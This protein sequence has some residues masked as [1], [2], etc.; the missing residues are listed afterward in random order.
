MRTLVAVAAGVVT[1]GL[2]LWMSANPAGAMAPSVEAGA[3]IAARWCGACHVIS[4]NGAGTDSA[5][6]FILIA[7]QRNAI[8]LKSFLERSHAKPM[9]GFT[10]STR[11]IDDLVAYIGSLEPPIVEQ[12]AERP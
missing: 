10:L 7:H 2:G 5:P 9:R 1:L 11:E 6:S 3:D 4:A 12:K 8:E